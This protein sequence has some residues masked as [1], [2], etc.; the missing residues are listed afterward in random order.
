MTFKALRV[1]KKE[2]VAEARFVDMDDEELMEGDVTVGVTHSTVNYKDGLVMAGRPGIVQRHP[3]IAGVDLAGIVQSSTH[4]QFRAGDEVLLNGYGLSQTHFGGYAEKARVPGDWLVKLPNGLTRAQTM[5]IG[6]AGYTAM[7]CVLALERLGMAPEQGPV[8]VTGAAGGVGSVAV[9]LLATAGWQVVASTGR[10]AEADYLKALGAA[11]IID[12]AELSEPGRP[13]GK[14]RWAAAVDSV[15]SHTLAN[16]VA[17]LMRGGAV[18]AC[19]LAGG[20]DLPMTVAPFILRGAQLIGVDSVWQPMNRRLEAWSRLARDLDQQ[21]LKEMTQTIPFARVM[22]AGA[23]I[24][25]GKVR[26]RIVVEI[27]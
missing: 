4:P 19:G 11:E 9:A 1:D 26:G 23:D 8:L 17:G 2:K 22:E 24:L 25:A 18:A 7:L 20:M 13:L 15:G 14:E 3:M 12:R 27:G 10:P 5:A 21:K 6:T 16:A